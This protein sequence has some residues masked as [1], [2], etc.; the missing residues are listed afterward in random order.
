VSF[1]TTDDVSGRVA[2]EG[3]TTIRAMVWTFAR[4]IDEDGS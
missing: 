4:V 3:A 1:I 2:S